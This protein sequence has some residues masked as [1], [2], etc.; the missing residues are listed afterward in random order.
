MTGILIRRDKNRCTHI[1]GRLHEDSG[2]EMAMYSLRGEVLY[3]TN[4]ADTL[5]L[6]F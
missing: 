6:D 1:E 5:I 4:S 3:E 2:R